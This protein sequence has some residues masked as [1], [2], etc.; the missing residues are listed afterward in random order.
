MA[1]KIASEIT[2]GRNESTPNLAELLQSRGVAWVDFAGWK[3]IE[4]VERAG[5]CDERCLLKMLNP[6]DMIRAAQP[7]LPPME[8]AE[9]DS[10]VKI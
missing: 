8:V 3:R 4:A 6:D 5:A 9:P 7:D 10:T 2:L 1:Q